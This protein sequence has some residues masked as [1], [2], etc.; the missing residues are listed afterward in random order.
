MLITHKIINMFFILILFLLN[1]NIKAKV[2]NNFLLAKRRSEA[3]DREIRKLENEEMRWRLQ[4]THQRRKLTL[5][6]FETL[7]KCIPLKV[8]HLRYR[9]ETE[10]FGRSDL[11]ER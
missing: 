5:P 2:Q 11:G 3:L 7:A 1:V 10:R 8:R 6:K 4:G 9:K